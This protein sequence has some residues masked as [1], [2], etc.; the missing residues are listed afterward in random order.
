MPEELDAK[1]SKA[2]S[3]QPKLRQ[4]IK[5][6]QKDFM[7]EVKD[8][9]AELLAELEEEDEKVKKHIEKKYSDRSTKIAKIGAKKKIMLIR[10]KDKKKGNLLKMRKFTSSTVD[11]KRYGSLNS[12]LLR[13]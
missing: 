1:A 2:L 12:L 4:K 9:E 3:K 6:K 5:K 13:K 10:R 11:K 7:E 8:L